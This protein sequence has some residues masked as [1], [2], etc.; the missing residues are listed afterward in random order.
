MVK[1]YNQ[2]SVSACRLCF[3]TLT[4]SKYTLLAQPA[5]DIELIETFPT[6]GRCVQILYMCMYIVHTGTGTCAVRTLLLTNSITQST[7]YK[8]RQ[9]TGIAWTWQSIPF[10][11]SESHQ[12]HSLCCLQPTN[13]IMHVAS[14]GTLRPDQL[15]KYKYYMYMYV[16]FPVTTA[17]QPRA[18][19]GNNR[20]SRIDNI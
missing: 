14:I 2:Q 17:Q 9:H 16:P 3:T 6:S 1:R 8:Y 10:H 13:W 20:P 15:V 4:K 18:F 12:C 5:K 19:M 7:N 11:R